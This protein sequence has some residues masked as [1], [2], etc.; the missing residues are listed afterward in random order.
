MFWQP[1]GK[2]SLEEAHAFFYGGDDRGLLV[3]NA[4]CVS[5]YQACNQN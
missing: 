4:L 2:L 5:K 1:L 3:I